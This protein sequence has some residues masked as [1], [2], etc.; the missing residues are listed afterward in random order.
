MRKISST[1]K[2]A[3]NKISF[4]IFFLILL[5]T[6]FLPSPAFSS[7]LSSIKSRPGLDEYITRTWTTE[8]GLNQN[9][10]TSLVQSKNGY[11]WIGTPTGLVR[12]DGVQFRH[13]S[14]ANTPALANDRITV[15]YEDESG[16]LWIGTDGGGL[17]SLTPS[18]PSLNYQW[19]HYTIQQGLSNNNIRAITSDW[20]GNVWVGTDYGLNRISMDGVRIYTIE[21]GL[22]DNIITA[23]ALDIRGDLWVGTLQG[24]L[25]RIQD[26]AVFNYGPESGLLNPSVLSLVTDPKENWALSHPERFPVNVNR[27]SRYE[28]LRVPGLGPVTVNRILERRRS[29]RLHGLEDIGKVGARL[30]KAQRYIKF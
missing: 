14:R 24:G 4:S 23:L 27:A 26:Y 20:Q 21:D 22:Y 16:N 15:L 10:I 30:L 19:K 29:G 3:T 18:P 5:L 13:F 2:E 9:T 1:Q 28:L 8:N 11:L 6:P 7:E 25:A 17:Y 12:F